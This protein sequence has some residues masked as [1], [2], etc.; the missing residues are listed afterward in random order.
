MGK[1]YDEYKK[2]QL[3]GNKK[4]NAQLIYILA[5]QHSKYDFLYSIEKGHTFNQF[6]LKTRLKGTKGEDC[7]LLQATQFEDGG[8]KLSIQ[9]LYMIEDIKNFIDYWDLDEYSI[10]MKYLQCF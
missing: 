5:A 4:N 8:I 10:F 2:L 6:W 7:I 1:L 9:G 3:E